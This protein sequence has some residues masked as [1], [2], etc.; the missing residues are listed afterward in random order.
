MLI[1]NAPRSVPIKCRE[2]SVA[3]RF[4]SAQ[5]RN[6]RLAGDADVVV[7][8]KAWLVAV[9]LITSRSSAVA[10]NASWAG[11]R[12]TRQ[13]HDLAFGGAC[14][15]VA[16]ESLRRLMRYLTER[17]VT[18]DTESGQKHW[19]ASNSGRSTETDPSYLSG[20]SCSSGRHF[21][22]SFLQAPPRPCCSAN[23][24]HHRVRT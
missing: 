2:P 1:E 4:L 6:D 17:F 16:S 10:V 7:P 11:A 22:Y 15:P 19:R 9:L 8:A 12:R 3:N 23:G 5:N 21:A 24:S 13:R 20:A 18:Q 14:S